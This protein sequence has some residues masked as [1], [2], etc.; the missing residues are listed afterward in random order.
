[1]NLNFMKRSFKILLL[2]FGGAIFC[3]GGCSSGPEKG[4][5]RLPEWALGG[6]VRPAGANPVITPDPQ[7]RF[8]LPDAPGFRRMDGER[9]VQSRRHRPG[10]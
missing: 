4:E 2:A 8:F 10:R 9:H 1:M 5:N 7:I 6:F 3:C